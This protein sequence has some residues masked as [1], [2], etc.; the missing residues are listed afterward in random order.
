MSKCRQSAYRL[1]KCKYWCKYSLHSQNMHTFAPKSKI[2]GS[3]THKKLLFIE[4]S[5]LSSPQKNIIACTSSRY[6]TKRSDAAP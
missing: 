5:S 6:F 1:P 3:R 4:D 2:L